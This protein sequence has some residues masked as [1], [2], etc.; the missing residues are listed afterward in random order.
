[1]RLGPQ[2]CRRRSW[3]LTAP[4][5]TAVTFVSVRAIDCF[6]EH[7]PWLSSGAVNTSVVSG[8]AT[9]VVLKTG[10]M[11]VF[12]ELAAKLA[13]MRP[14]NSFAIGVRHVSIMFLS[15]MGVMVPAVFLLAGLL[16]KGWTQAFLFGNCNGLLVRSSFYI[17]AYS[18]CRWCRSDARNAAHDCQCESRQGR[19]DDVK[20][21]SHRQASRLDYQSGRH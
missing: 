14:E 21:E 8:T 18:D 19:S 3:P 2:M 9:A 20:G 15:V 7:G 13:K 12:G 5:W 10:S 6:V 16:G 17:A 11:T 4:N 1:M